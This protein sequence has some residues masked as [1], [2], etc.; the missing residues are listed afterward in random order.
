MDYATLF[1]ERKDDPL[2]NTSYPL[3]PGDWAQYRAKG[4]LGFDGER[5]MSF[6]IHIPFCQQLCSFCEYTRM[7]CPSADLQLRYVATLARDVDSFVRRHPDIELLGLDIGG[8]TPTALCGE[9]FGALMRLFASATGRLRLSSGFEPSIEATFGTMTRAKAAAI[10]RAG[11]KRVSLGVQSAS[12][13]VLGENHRQGASMELMQNVMAT[14]RG[15]GI[16]KVNLDLMYGLKGQSI[17]SLA[18][19]LRTIGLLNPEQV[20]LYELRTNITGEHCHMDKEGLLTAYATLHR[21]LT[22]M[23]Y[24]AR[25][26]ENTFSKDPSDKGVSSYLRSRMLHGA[27]YKGFGISAQSMSSEGLA[28]NVGKSQRGLK[29]LLGRDTFA[30]EF[31]YRLPPAERAA[32]YIAIGAYN[33]SFSLRRLSAILGADSAQHYHEQLQ[34]AIGR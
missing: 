8:G 2:Y 32:K 19:D 7:V 17:G 9:A 22:A 18:D 25:F 29:S 10:A 11:I 4:P 33:G 31:T 16:A 5:E 3:S 24:H 15:E 23:G 13:S 21:G 12:G 6:Y 34:F 27:S 30:E 1:D 26:G 14:L 28:Y 20:T